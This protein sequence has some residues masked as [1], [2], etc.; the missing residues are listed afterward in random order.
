MLSDSLKKETERV[1]D[2]LI[3]ESCRKEFSCGANA[4]KCWC[5]EVELKSV[6]LEEIR[7]KFEQCLCKR[8]LEAM[9]FEKTGILKE[10]P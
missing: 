1:G 5:F 4:G 9:N 2:K 10:H 6:A 3:C 8:C 7:E